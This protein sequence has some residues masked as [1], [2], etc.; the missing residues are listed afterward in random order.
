MND[1]NNLI[2]EIPLRTACATSDDEGHQ[3]EREMY[4]V[5][6]EVLKDMPP[7][8]VH[9]G[10]AIRIKT[11]SNQDYSHTDFNEYDK[12]LKFLMMTYP[13]VH[14]VC[15]MDR[16]NEYSVIYYWK[17]EV[18]EG[19]PVLL[20]AHYDVVP[21]E[22]SSINSWNLAPFSGEIKQGYIYGR[23]A[24]DDKNQVISIMEALEYSIE[25]GFKPKRDIYIAFGFDEEV[26][27]EKGAKTM[28]SIF[29]EKN[30]QFEFVLDEGGAIIEGIVEGIDIP[31]G[32]IGVAEKGSSN[33]RIITSGDEGHSSMP[34]ENSAIGKLSTIINNVE[35][36]PM[37]AKLTSPVERMFRLMS[38]YMGKAG[39]LLNHAKLVFPLLKRKLSKSKT[40]NAMIRT[41]ISFTMTGGGETEN[42]LP[43][44][45]WVNANIRILPGDS[46][47]GVMKHIKKINKGIDFEMK[48]MNREE[49]SDVSPYDSESYLMIEK[50]IKQVF[51]GVEVMPYLMAGSTDS[52]KY[53]GLCEKIYRFSA[54]KMNQDDL[55]SIHG[56]NE[57]ISVENL[58]KM[59]LFYKILLEEFLQ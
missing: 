43:K 30:L 33:L 50:K 57:R 23:G 12:F 55:D 48:V 7:C 59:V 16:V 37:P 9:L 11:I 8:A 22:K 56:P 38:P 14:Q 29:Q 3:E 24:M 53:S 34:T 49:G 58:Q 54:V 45:A 26:G 17:S 46:L 25:N 18:H 47:D 27:G 19:K 13:K 21:V 4:E 15:Q 42:I 6:E 35:K 44:T 36:N 20:T 51:D 39:I 52:R 2:R 32:L 40:M 41:T 31:I 5:K 10:E 28:A 1:H